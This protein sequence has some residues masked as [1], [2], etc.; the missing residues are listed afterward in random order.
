MEADLLM[1]DRD[2]YGAVLRHAFQVIYD[3]GRDSWTAEPE[4]RQLTELLH[5]W[6]EP[7]S[8]VLDVGA[9][10]G[11]DTRRLLA[12]G[13][14]VVGVDLID[15]PE[16]KELAGQWGERV[17]FVL[18]DVTAVTDP[19]G[20]DAVMDNGALHHQ[21]PAD[22][23][24]YLER[25]RQALRPGGVLAISLFVRP[26]EEPQGLLRESPN[27]RLA[28]EF[29]RAEAVEL[30]AGAGFAVLAERRVPRSSRSDWA[31]LLLIARARESG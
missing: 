23:Q 10:R 30:L 15:L 5:Q 8:R 27:G 1:A 2:D 4:M 16:W 25:L 6:I 26:P 7:G 20:F 3:D 31:Y 11:L 18:G 14:R 29:T 19:E 17:S 24:K 28:R 9:G 12:L 13:H 21:H 22:Y